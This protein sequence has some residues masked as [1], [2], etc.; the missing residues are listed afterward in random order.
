[1]VRQNRRRMD[2]SKRRRHHSP[3]IWKKFWMSRRLNPPSLAHGFPSNLPPGIQM[4]LAGKCP[5]DGSSLGNHLCTSGIISIAVLNGGYPNLSIFFSGLS[6][7]FLA[8]HFRM[9]IPKIEVLVSLNGCQC[10][11]LFRRVD[12]RLS[13]GWGLLKASCHSNFS[14]CQETVASCVQR[15]RVA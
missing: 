5:K 14:H 8:F 3:S 10:R 4:W 6:P 11:T 9:T 12:D 13:A 2:R 15:R 1:M 7:Y